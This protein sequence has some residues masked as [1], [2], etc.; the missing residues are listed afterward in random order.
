MEKGKCTM[1]GMCCQAIVLNLHPKSF[2]YEEELCDEYKD[3]FDRG[4]KLCDSEFAS[5]FFESITEEDAL[6]INPYLKTWGLNGGTKYYY[7]C[8]KFD[9]ST[10]SCTVNG[11]KPH[12]CSGYPWYGRS[13]NPKDPL[14]SASCGYHIDRE[15]MRVVDVLRLLKDKLSIEKSG[16]NDKAEADSI[17]AI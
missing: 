11:Q 17:K 12:T 10:N 14:Y 15:R 8:T 3:R 9:K 13:P 6:A 5:L 4:E 7:R 16:S 1:C 2:R